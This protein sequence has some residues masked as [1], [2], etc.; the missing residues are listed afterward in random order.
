MHAVSQF[1]IGCL[2]ALLSGVAFFAHAGELT[3]SSSAARL[4]TLG[5]DQAKMEWRGRGSAIGNQRFCISS[6][7]GSYRLTVRIENYSSPP[8]SQ[9]LQYT[10]LFMAPDG[11]QHLQSLSSGELREFT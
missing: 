3:Q 5:G 2:I 10:L 6:T 11:K 8:N 9:P 1:V 4:V 7:T